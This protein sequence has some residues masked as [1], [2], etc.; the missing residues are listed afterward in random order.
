MIAIDMEM[1]KK[2]D[3]CP[4]RQI[5][6]ARCQITGKSTSHHPTFKPMDQTKRPKWCPLID[7]TQYEDNGK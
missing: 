6:L 5:N 7:L 4:C 1:P 2:C 3:D